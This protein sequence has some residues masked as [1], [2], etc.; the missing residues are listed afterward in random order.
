MTKLFRNELAE[1]G[2]R[3]AHISKNDNNDLILR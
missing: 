2:L 3:I 1:F